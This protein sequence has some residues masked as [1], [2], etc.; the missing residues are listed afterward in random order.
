MRTTV[1][2]VMLLRQSLVVQLKAVVR[3]YFGESAEKKHK[4]KKQY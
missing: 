3:M 2:L 1:L 4:E